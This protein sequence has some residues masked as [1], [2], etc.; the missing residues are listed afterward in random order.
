MSDNKNTPKSSYSD[1]RGIH[2]AVPIILLAFAVFLALCYITQGTG[3][4]G[5]A[6]SKVMLGLFSY[7]AY[8]LPVLIAAHALFYA[9]DIQEKRILSRTIFSL[10]ALI[11][12]SSL[13][14]VIGNWGAELTFTPKQFYSD[15]Q[16][17][18][19]GGFIGSIVAYAIV[20]LF[21][22]VGLIVIAIAVFALYISYFF[23]K[24]QSATAKILLG[25]LAAIA[26]GFAKIERGI[27]SLFSRHHK[28][29]EEEKRRK[30]EEK[31][32]DLYDDEFFAVDNG[33]K[34]LK[35]DEL[36]ILE[37]RSRE[38]LEAN[39]TLHETVFHKGAYE[40]DEPETTSRIHE[41][42]ARD[43]KRERKIYEED[44]SD[45]E[46]E[47]KG[48]PTVKENDIIYEN[49]QESAPKT[50]AYSRKDFGLDD[51]AEN[52]FTKDFDPLDISTNYTYASKP[53]SRAAMRDTPTV[54][55]TVKP[56]KTFSEE[57]IAA[58]RRKAEFEMKKKMFAEAYAKQKAEAER[59]EAERVE[60]VTVE[61]DLEPVTVEP[62]LEPVTV[63]PDLEPVAVEPEVEP[64]LGGFDTKKTVEFRESVP[65][66]F[67]AK[68]T[69]SSIFET[70]EKPIA[71]DTFEPMTEESDSSRKAA[72]FS[73][74]IFE[75]SKKKPEE[76]FKTYV[77]PADYL[78]REA[79]KKEERRA[80]REEALRLER[81]ML[82]P[83]PEPYEEELDEEEEL[84][85]PE[86][87]EPE[88]V[89]EPKEIPEEEQNE[90]VKEYR[91]MFTIFDDKADEDHG[92]EEMDEPATDEE[93]D[94]DLPPFDM[95]K[96]APT[97]RP[98]YEDDEDIEE[99]PPKPKGPDY[100]NYRFPSPDLMSKGN[101]DEDESV[102][103]EIQENAEKL[104]D[105]LES[106][107]VTASIK[108][109]EHGPRITRYEVVPARGVKVSSITNLFDDIALALAADGI[110]MEAPIPGKSAIGFE[111]PNK[112]PSTVMLR[113]LI[114]TDEFTNA[115][116]K[117]T[118]CIGKDVTGSPV[119]GDIAKMPHV[120]IAGATGMGKS[121]CMNAIL[122]SMLYKAKPNEVK[123]I[124]IDPKKV[125]FNGYNG[126]PHLLVPVVTD[127]KQAAGA[128]MW[129]VEQME[130]RYELIE[131]LFVRNIE[132][133]NAKVTED[134]TLGEP[135]PKIVIVIDELND[136]MIQVRDPV[137]NLIMSIAQKARAAGI[138]LI[139]GTQRPSVNVIT[140]VIKANIPSRIACKVSSNVDSRTILEQAG[141]EKLLNNG[142]MLFWP[143]GKPKPIRVQGAYVADREVEAIM[144]FLKTQAK[145]Q[146]YDSQALEE[147][148]RAAQKCV[149]KK[150]SDS[151]GRD[152]GS[153]DSDNEG[154]LGNQK[155][156]D[157]VDLAISQGKISTS[158]LQR[159]IGLGYGKAAKFIDTMESLGIVSE[160]NG[161][162]PR[163]VLITRDEWHE[164]LS[165][166]SID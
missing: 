91:K 103:E 26:G 76:E 162:K 116:A 94:E 36:G 53:S 121:V 30:I 24:G 50:Q 85:A 158:L 152:V 83:E 112:K 150:D 13:I 163:D 95:P 46:W 82:S 113:D 119:F 129:A 106:F 37:T 45:A 66:T 126:I 72:E 75:E 21:G 64:V 40:A 29:K 128:L 124:M 131:K 110:R 145:G 133:Y 48:E 5:N 136:L 127:P 17:K 93:E 8:A 10:V 18:I 135:M 2:R 132:A 9:S 130:K 63:E 22:S 102:S 23:A 89:F 55:E 99:E 155:F 58:A 96:S 27:K 16:E 43:Q 81:T 14:Y 56:E 31:S 34:Q 67:E 35:I 115:G 78:S 90:A 51:S 41:V 62:D 42:P 74:F 1:L 59:A 161:Q 79:Q 118:V 25:L 159:K 60:P 3:A 6:I 86:E 134:P 160:P 69:E 148:N 122:I 108:S 117:T 114:D 142:D 164:K 107:R 140:G 137:E 143:V 101:Y 100:S 80:E 77:S 84:I 154:Y 109:V 4:F 39:P 68:R 97:S 44:F 157:A 61:P 12:F 54:T 111:I 7:A 70:I 57:D 88:E 156:L 49:Y 87:L 151:D 32:A 120:L 65:E 28:A 139:I 123:F 141:A 52:V 73:A 138:H 71:E 125:E 153:N 33:M 149:K 11:T 166:L 98:T 92:E 47:V 20:K 165:R 19:G 104:I 147:I 144:K 105:T 146:T 15:G 38:S